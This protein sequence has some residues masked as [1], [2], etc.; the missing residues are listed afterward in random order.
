MIARADVEVLEWAARRRKFGRMY[1][2]GPYPKQRM[3]FGLGATKRERLLIAANQ[4]GK[5]ES[6][7]YETA[8]HLT[9]DYPD[10][11]VGRRFTKPTRGWAAG[12]TA[13]LTRD[14]QQKKLMG[15]PGVEEEFGTGLIPKDAIVD[16]S[17]ARSV[18]DALDT[19]QVR[20]KSGGVSTLTFKSYVQGRTKFAS[21]PIDFGWLDEECP[22]DIYSECLTRTTAT[23]GMIFGTYTPLE[24][25]TL[26]TNRFLKEHSPDRAYVTMTI[27]DAEHIP[28]E[29]RQAIIDG[30]PAHER[31]ARSMGIPMR[32]SGRVYPFGDEQVVE[33]PRRD[34]EI[35][36]YWAKGWGLDFGVSQNTTDHA[37]GALLGL[38]D[39]E[40]DVLY[41]HREI[42]IFGQAPLMHVHAIQS[43]AAQ[44]PC[45]W[46][47]DGHK[48]GPGDGQETV[49]T[50]AIYKKLGLRMHHDHTTFDVGGYSVEAG[51]LDITSRI[52]TNRLK[53]ST[54]CVQLLDEFRGY[55]RKDGKVVPKNDDLLSCLRQLVMGKRFMQPVPLGGTFTRPKEQPIANDVEFDYF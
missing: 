52:Q 54:N 10:W 39:R 14:V 49:A 36:P 46:P 41:I 26:L 28:P 13:E 23:G 38:W 6:G 11:W 48:T 4:V 42:K 7:A 30:Y 5:T 51:I 37:F 8:L 25:D 53:I 15:A 50:A 33:P 20:H 2:F 55:Y 34:N 19:V 40:T 32:G 47:H 16:T 31:E 1:F 12:E 27:H 45:L 18:T 35:A 43:I 9:G 29:K 44:V 24:G 21:E 22:M 17:L 3:F